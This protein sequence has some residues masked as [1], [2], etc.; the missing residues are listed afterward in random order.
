M[1]LSVICFVIILIFAGCGSLYILLD[2]D[3]LSG[4]LP[5]ANDNSIFVVNVEG[6]LD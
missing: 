2:R 5:A 4:S 3:S 1:K 6:T